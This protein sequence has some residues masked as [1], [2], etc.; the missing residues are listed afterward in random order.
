MDDDIQFSRNRYLFVALYHMYLIW[1]S[2]DIQSK[3]T[4]QIWKKDIP[5]STMNIEFKPFM[6]VRLALCVAAV[7]YIL[8]CIIWFGLWGCC[9]D[10][11]LSLRKTVKF[12]KCIGAG[13]L[14]M[15][16]FICFTSPIF[17]IPT[18]YSPRDC[19]WMVWKEMGLGVVHLLMMV[20]QII[21]LNVV[22]D[23]LLDL[24]DGEIPMASVVESNL[25]PERCNQ[26]ENIN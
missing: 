15:D 23:F 26:E 14:L 18:R 24:K 11:V 10:T 19:Y 13:V 1:V 16:F 25:D 12:I 4:L 9:S 22:I 21:E 6:E 20:F 3:W 2:Y 7:V 8:G 5:G 17:S